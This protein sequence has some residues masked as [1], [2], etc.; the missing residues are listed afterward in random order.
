MS[1]VKLAVGNNSVE[2]NEDEPLRWTTKE[3]VGKGRHA[4]ET[5]YSADLTILEQGFSHTLLTSLKDAWIKHSY[6]V[7]MPT[8][9]VEIYRI[10]K[11][12]KVLQARFA[13]I[14]RE[15]GHRQQAFQHID[16]SLLTGLWAIRKEIPDHYLRSFRSF[17]IRERDNHRI[18]TPDLHKGDFPT[19]PDGEPIGTI[20]RLRQ[21]VLASALPRATLVQ[22]LNITEA[23]FEAGELK[24][25]IFAF[26][27]LLLSRA[28]RPESF[29][30]LRI[31]DFS[32]DSTGEVKVYFLTFTIPKARTHQRPTAPVRIHRD[33]GALLERQRDAV[34]REYG[35]LVEAKNTALAHDGFDA[36]EFFTVGD[37]PLFPVN[38]YR[39]KQSSKDRLAMLRTASAFTKSYLDPLKSL[40]GAKI[41][42]TA[43][44]HTMGT[45]LAAAG[46]STST[47]AAVLLHAND[48]SARVYVDLLFTEVIDQITESLEPAFL[49][50][51]PVFE[52]FVKSTDSISSAKRIVSSTHDR[53]HRETTGECGQAEVCQYAPIACYECARFRPC[54][55]TDHTINLERVQREI[56]IARAGGLP[57]RIDAQRYTH[58][59]NCIRVVINVCEAKRAEMEA[60]PVVKR[61]TK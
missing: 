42:C 32:I 35:Q 31:R 44:R 33:V 57:R 59:A 14:Y 46:C 24:L 18:F 37:L 8:L 50:H 2:W 22:I 1:L 56:D 26:S 17:Y 27:R 48:S 61:S 21:N 16:T 10:L 9:N 30:L 28:A 12:L 49:E 43:I 4:E 60:H 41:T 51:F 15:R 53:K 54:Y 55:D 40:T 47:I 39:L 23:A 19:N 7:R 6:R 11:I 20:G 38:P 29:R 52:A 13:D 5:C 25:S 34:I 3:T 36:N 45:Q 58:I